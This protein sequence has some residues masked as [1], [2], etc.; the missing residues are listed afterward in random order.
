MPENA[1]RAPHDAVPGESAPGLIGLLA[2]TSR[3]DALAR[4]A[5]VVFAAAAAVF[6]WLE[7]A[8]SPF[9]Y[10]DRPAAVPRLQRVVLP[11]FNLAF[12]ALILL[13]LLRRLDAVAGAWPRAFWRRLVVG[14]GCLFAG[15]AAGAL[16]ERVATLPRRSLQ[17]VAFALF[18]LILI[19]ALERRPHFRSPPARPPGGIE[20][21]DRQTG[22]ERLLAWPAATFFVLGLTVYFVFIPFAESSDSA[23][24][25]VSELY[26]FVLLDAYLVARLVYLSRAA[27]PTPWRMIYSALLLPWIVVLATDLSLVAARTVA[28]WPLESAAWLSWNLSHVL[29][30]LAIR[31]RHHPH[32]A[33]RQPAG[34]SPAAGKQVPS[35][36]VSARTLGLGVAFPVLHLLAYRFE[37]LDPVSRGAREDVVVA[38]LL[39]FGVIALVQHRHLERRAQALWLDRVTFEEELRES[40]AD[41][42]LIIERHRTQETRQR[43]ERRF[44]YAFRA[45]P[46]PLAISNLKSGRLLEANPAFEQAFG[47][48]R[49]EVIGR[50]A[51]EIGLWSDGAEAARVNRRIAEQQEIHEMEV[52]FRSK[53]AAPVP[54]I[55]SAAEI[56]LDGERCLLSIVQD[57]GQRRRALA[58][59]RA[60][61]AAVDGAAAAILELDAAGRVRSWNVAAQRLCGRAAEGQPAGELLGP[62][63]AVEE[64][65]G[66]TQWRGEL[67]L[68]ESGVVVDAWCCRLAAAGEGGALLV[69]VARG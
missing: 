52:T 68:A 27:G 22:A 13:S 17:V 28:G 44:D 34:D 24:N 36:L 12:V 66:T 23:S 38:W 64:M 39:V 31:L 42:R 35:L 58:R 45:C 54:A 67:E 40:E 56:E 26:Y 69:A 30:V 10:P 63:A 14:Y 49:D 43:M 32:A 21:G 11:L 61:A 4:A 20:G 16:P 65:L 19:R 50:S 29:Q 6:V 33:E 2:T 47:F 51:E 57:V 41:L 60:A 55:L 15:L 53:S 62:A 3:R 48:S 25:L 46:Y 18:Y 59:L 1:D 9:V 5:L 7:L 8:G 37:L